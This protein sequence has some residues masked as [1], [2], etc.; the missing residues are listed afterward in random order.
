[1]INAG[2]QG[3][4]GDALVIPGHTYTIVRF[5]HLSPGDI[6]IID[7]DH[8]EEHIFAGYAQGQPYRVLRPESEDFFLWPATV[9]D[10]VAAR[11]GSPL[12][13]GVVQAMSREHRR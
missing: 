7:L 10:L 3:R 9:V 6:Y 8:P 12:P 4:L 1:M 13:Q 5:A 2:I 11:K